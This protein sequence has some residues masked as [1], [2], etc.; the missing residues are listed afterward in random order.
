MWGGLHVW[1][2]GIDRGRASQPGKG[3]RCVCVCVCV[4]VSLC[5]CLCV[6]LCVCLCVCVGGEGVCVCVCP[7][8]RPSHVNPRGEKPVNG[9]PPKVG[10]LCRSKEPGAVPSAQV[11]MISAEMWRHGQRRKPNHLNQACRR[12][13]FSPHPK[14]VHFLGTQRMGHCSLSALSHL[15]VWPQISH[16]PL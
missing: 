1:C 16:P 10:T 9:W 11:P 6:S 3:E 13:A 15:A 5:V 7:G 2:V 8:P 4:C 12:H 14:L